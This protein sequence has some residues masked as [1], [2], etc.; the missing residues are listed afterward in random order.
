MW[1]V[2][3]RINSRSMAL[4][5]KLLLALTMLSLLSMLCFGCGKPKLAEPEGKP[6]YTL[7]DATGTKVSFTKKPERIVSLSIS[8]DEILL[9]LVEPKRIV[10][11]TKYV[12]DEGI[13]NATEQAKAVKGRVQN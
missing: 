9:D 2:V 7:T 3:K 13:S 4:L 1:L 10:A 12:D 6:I 11:L 5:F 8:T